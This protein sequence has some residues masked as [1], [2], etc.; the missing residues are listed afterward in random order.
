VTAAPLRGDGLTALTLV[1]VRRVRN[2]P[3]VPS[4]KRI[5]YF[6]GVQM[7]D[8]GEWRRGDVLRAIEA[9]QGDDVYLAL[10][11]DQFAWAKVDR[12][13][14]GRQ[15]GRLRFFRDRRSNLPGYAHRLAVAELPIPADAGLVE[16]TH[17]V[18]GANGLIAAEYNHFGPKI[19]THF[20][21]FLRTKLD[22]D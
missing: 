15:Y 3:P 10:G 6:Y 16:P 22:Y 12:V 21:D 14:R 5:V 17:V 8:G 9:L 18:L 2:T 13:P 19:T 4:V 20:R 11:D 7:D 1:S